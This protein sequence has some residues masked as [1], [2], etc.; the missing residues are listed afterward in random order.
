MWSHEEIF[1]RWEDMNVFI[2][3]TAWLNTRAL[4]ADKLERQYILFHVLSQST[5]SKCW[6]LTCGDREDTLSFS[7]VCLCPY[8]SISGP[9]NPGP[10][11]NRYHPFHMAYLEVHPLGSTWHRRSGDPDQSFVHSGWLPGWSPSVG[12]WWCCHIYRFPA[13]GHRWLVWCQGQSFQP[14]ISQ[15]ILI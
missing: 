13:S 12:T 7:T 15:R 5:A 11:H 14:T 1:V 3:A 10:D 9:H 6:M 8:I 2:L 4:K